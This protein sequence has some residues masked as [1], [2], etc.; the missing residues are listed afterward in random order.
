[1]ITLTINGRQREL[2]GPTNLVD[3]LHAS[4]VNLQ[5]IAVA[6]NGDVVE[7]DMFAHI[8]LDEGDEVEIVWPVGGG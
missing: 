8:I 5:F 1:M 2:E 7:R 6:H 3:F 4:G